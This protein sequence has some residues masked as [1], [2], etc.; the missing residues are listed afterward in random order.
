MGGGGTGVAEERLEVARESLRA[1]LA[2]V[3]PERGKREGEEVRMDC[4]RDQS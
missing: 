4:F 3:R 2:R 1:R